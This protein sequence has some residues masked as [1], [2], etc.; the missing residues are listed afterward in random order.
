MYLRANNVFASYKT[1]LKI[2]SVSPN[3]RVQI[4]FLEVWDFLECDNGEAVRG[5]KWSSWALCPF[6]LVLATADLTDRRILSF[7]TQDHQRWISN[8]QIDI[9]YL[10]K[11][12]LYLQSIL[13][14]SPLNP[15]ELLTDRSRFKQQLD[16]YTWPFQRKS[17]HPLTQFKQLQIWLTAEDYHLKNSPRVLPRIFDRV[18]GG[19]QM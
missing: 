8:N 17:V 4:K 3:T 7:T 9:L 12:K 18:R 2:S 15:V 6:D 19:Y 11:K 1:K 16:H 14:L 10:Q 5:R 13:I